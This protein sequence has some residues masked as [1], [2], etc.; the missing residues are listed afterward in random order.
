MGIDLN[1]LNQ[2]VNKQTTSRI[3]RKLIKFCA[4]CDNEE[5]KSKISGKINSKIKTKG[6]LYFLMEYDR[7]YKYPFLTSLFQLVNK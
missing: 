7:F 3:K 6:D 5:L 1:P 2:P 4:A